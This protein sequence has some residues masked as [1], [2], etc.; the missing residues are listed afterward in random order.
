ML[1][2]SIPKKWSVVYNG[3]PKDFC[4]KTSNIQKEMCV[5]TVGALKRSNIKRKGIGTFIEIAK[6]FPEYDF[7]IVG[8]PIDDVIKSIKKRAPDNVRLLG[9][10]QENELIK[11]YKKCA[12]YLQPST[13][14]AF[15]VS[16]V[17]GMLCECIPVV[18]N[19]GALPEIVGNAGVV[20]EYG[21]IKDIVMG[22]KKAL[23]LSQKNEMRKKA[24][25]R[26]KMFSLER[27]ERELVKIISEMFT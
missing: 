15:G 12:V 4:N 13:H 6:Y 9:Y 17:E 14:E 27:R 5:L 23:E 25:E 1:K 21:N 2:I 22:V 11:V 24:K 10:L 20:V 19:K 8:K 18:T 3:V 7:L 16:V 26:A